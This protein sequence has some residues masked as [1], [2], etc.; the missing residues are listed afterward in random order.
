MTG[1]YNLAT[2]RMSPELL[3]ALE[4]SEPRLNESDVSLF[5]FPIHTY[6]CWTRGEYVYL[7]KLRALHKP[8]GLGLTVL[9]EK[10]V[11]H[12]LARAAVAGLTAMVD[13]ALKE[14]KK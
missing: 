12:L 4:S 11:E 2:L 8:T 9:C 3:K 5:T 13:A 6:Y 7:A 14:G 10:A 1:P